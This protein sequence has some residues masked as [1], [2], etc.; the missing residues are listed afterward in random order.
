MTTNDTPKN[1]VHWN[2]E[3]DYPDLCGK[4]RT[5]LQSVTDPE[6]GLSVIQLGLIRNL[7]ITPDRAS[8]EMILTTPFCPYGPAMLEQVRNKVEEILERT[9]SIEL[10]IEPWD[11]SYME[12]GIDPTWGLY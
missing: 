5:G 3:K 7:Y 12:D 9:T 11:I 2:A 8:V 10:G 4:V 6:L 1:Q